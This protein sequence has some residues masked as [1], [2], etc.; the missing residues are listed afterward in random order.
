[1]NQDDKVMATRVLN[2]GKLTLDQV[3]QLIAE[4]GRSGR[5][6][7]D[8][9]VGRGFLSPHDFDAPKPASLPTAQ[10]MLVFVALMVLMG[11]AL[12]VTKRVQ[13]RKPPP[14]VTHE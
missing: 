13:E 7:R 10:V 5:S 2:A 8:V 6:F 14:P 4:A 1:M 12:L 11:A 9:A 3:Q